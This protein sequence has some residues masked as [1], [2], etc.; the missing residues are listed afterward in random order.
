MKDGKKADFNI[1]RVSSRAN[2]KARDQIRTLLVGV[3]AVCLPDLGIGIV[4][5][6]LLAELIHERVNAGAL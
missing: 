3:D 6:E 2:Q 5:L 1:R 4:P